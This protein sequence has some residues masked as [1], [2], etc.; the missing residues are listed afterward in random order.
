MSE[1][2]DSVV[3]FARKTLENNTRIFKQAKTLTD[4][5]Y[6]VTLIGIK[7]NHLPTE[8]KQES[9]DIVRV[10]KIT[11]DL[12][13]LRRASKRLI[14][15]YPAYVV[16]KWIVTHLFALYQFFVAS[17]GRSL[18]S[19]LSRPLRVA[20]SARRTFRTIA[21]WVYRTLRLA[22]VQWFVR[23]RLH[24]AKNRVW[25]GLNVA[26][27]RWNVQSRIIRFRTRFRSPQ[28]PRR[29]G[30]G[31]FRRIHR[32]ANRRLNRMLNRVLRRV[33]NHARWFVMSYN[34]YRQSYRVM[35]ERDLQPDVVQANDLNTLIVAIAAARHHDVPLIYDAQ[36]LYTEIH[37]LPR[38]Y[39][40]VLTVQEF[41][42]IRM[43][44]RVTVVN[45][46]IAEVM[47]KRYRV[48]VNEV[49][50]NCPPF[51][52]VQDVEA[53]PGTTAREK[54]DIDLDVPVVLYSGGLSTQ[55]GLENLVTAMRNVPETVLVILGEGP[56][57][58]ELEDMTVELGIEDRV[59][60]S[61][62]V[63]HEEVPAF[64]TSADIGV[65]PY[66]HVGMNH[67]LCSP[68]KLFHYIMAELVIV[69][70]EFPFLKHVIEGNDIGG[71]FDPDDPQSMAAA[72]N[73]MVKD[74]KRLNRHRENVAQAKYTYTW[75][76]EAEKFLAQYEAVH[77]DGPVD[78][79]PTST[80]AAEAAP[81]VAQD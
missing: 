81:T 10:G 19:V 69:G 58:E 11:P 27:V 35:K 73:D 12:R 3:L 1:D 5:G 72:L 23:S 4:E 15:L 67:Y 9:Y 28:T 33:L 7:P 37:T 59:Y 22:S 46:F 43:A 34:Y 18:R 70:S 57:R 77:E 65:V 16:L 6:N 8:E 54:F 25:R 30:G 13:R 74:P 78:S 56:L 52:P 68:S 24:R 20:T 63:P 42:L 61:D 39:K 44:D 31:R 48:E 53:R 40:Y 64:I 55:R 41:V 36:E 38:W 29:S 21:R 76:N 49:L 2:G 14:P 79:E 50:L 80:Q 26:G 47:E 45:P 66:E 51:D 32:W 60:F 17:I 62:F 75:E 71:T